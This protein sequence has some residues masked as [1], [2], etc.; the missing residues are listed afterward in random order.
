MSQVLVTGF[1]PYA[2]EED[3]PSGAIARRL[4]GTRT[5]GV[6]FRGCELPV[7]SGQAPLLLRAAITDEPP[8]AVVLTG[9]TPARTRPALERVAINT[10]DFPIPD[11][12]GVVAVDDPIVEGGPAAYFST[13][14][15]KAILGRWREC[16]IDGYV[17]NSAGTYLC[18]QLFYLA[19][20]ATEGTPTRCGLV[21]V[22]VPSE[23]FPLDV[24]TTAVRT[25]AVVAATHTGPDLRLGA[26]ST[27]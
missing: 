19:R 20:Q 17:S 7:S 6:T 22:P 21:H 3:N 15:I 1:G 2:E 18:N 25:A 8:D 27:S 16:A 4:D 11:V 13:L 9:V 10:A 5:G 23:T 26:G 12:D 14:P 24:L